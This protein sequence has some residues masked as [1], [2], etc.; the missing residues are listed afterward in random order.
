L[1]NQ[2]QRL[3]N[4]QADDDFLPEHI[5]LG[6]RI[7]ANHLVEYFHLLKGLGVNHIG[8]NLRFNSDPIEKTVERFTRKVLPHFHKNITA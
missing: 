2:R 3:T 6:F 5:H 8:V 7:G 1:L 4:F